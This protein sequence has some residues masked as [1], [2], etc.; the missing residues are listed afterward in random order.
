MSGRI[1][2]TVSV[3]R[4]IRFDCVDH[5]LANMFDFLRAVPDEADHTSGFVDVSTFRDEHGFY[6]FTPPQEGRPGTSSYLLSRA[7]RLLRDFLQEE[8]PCD[9]VIHGASLVIDGTRF[10]IIGEKG[11]GKTTVSL[12]C[13]ADGHQVEGDEHVVVCRDHVVARARSMRI[14]QGSLGIVSELDDMIQSSPHI[15]DWNGDLIYSLEPRLPGGK[16]VIETGPADILLFLTA[17]HGG[18]TSV[19]PLHDEIAFKWLIKMTVL[20]K[21]GKAVALAR[22][23]NLVRS[24]RV[25]QMA[26]GDL[27]RAS[28]HLRQLSRM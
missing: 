3:N 13:L 19:K 11:A 6:D 1:V 21:A 28:W 18:A 9:P 17:N 25:M 8:A 22:L 14:K 7:H 12:R 2:Q 26:V 24:T 27:D 20:P 16:W 15:A 10:I 4:T 23:H 5:D